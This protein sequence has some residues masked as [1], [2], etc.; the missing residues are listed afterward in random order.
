MVSREKSSGPSTMAL[1]CSLAKQWVKSN[2]ERHEDGVVAKAVMYKH[3]EDHCREQGRNT[4][5][6][7]I[8]G[9]VV[10]S[11]F[12]DVNIRRLGGRDNLKYYYCGIQAKESSPYAADNATTTR[13]KRRLR[14]RELATEKADVH[15][16]LR[17]V[18]A[19]YE[20]GP[21]HASVCKQD[22]FDRYVQD[23]VTTGADPLPL[24]CF[25]MVMS[26][27]LPQLTRRKV[28]PRANQHKFYFGLQERPVPL[29]LET[30]TVEHLANCDEMFSNGRLKYREEVDQPE[31]EDEYSSR[32]PASN[33]SASSSSASESVQMDITE[34]GEATAHEYHHQH[35]SIKDEPVD[36]SYPTLRLKEE[37]VA[38][39][40]DYLV[41]KNEPLD[42]HLPK[43]L[44]EYA[45][46]FNYSVKRSPERSPSVV[47][48]LSGSPSPPVKEHKAR[49]IYKPRFH[50]QDENSWNSDSEV[51][52]EPSEV[53]YCGESATESRSF[54]SEWLVASFEECSSSS[55]NREDVL[56][57]YEKFCSLYHETPVP[58]SSLD[59]AV[60]KE[61]DGVVTTIHPSGKTYYNGLQVKPSGQLSRF[62]SDVPETNDVYG[63]WKDTSQH[64]ME[65]SPPTGAAPRASPRLLDDGDASQE[66]YGEK[67][68]IDG[69][70]EDF[71]S[72]PEVM[73]DGKFYL[74]MW[75]TENFESVP[76]S[77]VL[78]ADAYRHYEA[79][80]KSINQT[81]FE[82]NVFGKI[83]RQVFPKVS[84][85]RLGG[86]IK[87][88]YHYCGIAVKHSSPLFQYMSGKDPAQRSRKKE[89]ATDNKSAE[90]VIDWLQ[91]NYEPGKEHAIMKSEVF[92]KYCDF[93]TSRNEN[94]V[95][96]NYFGKL[97]KHCFPQVEVRKCGG[98]S[99][100]TWYYNGLLPKGDDRAGS[101]Y[102]RSHVA[103]PAPPPHG[104]DELVRGEGGG[105][106]GGGG[107]PSPGDLKVP[108]SHG[109]YQRGA[110]PTLREDLLASMSVHSTSSPI[111]ITASE[112]ACVSST[113]YGLMGSPLMLQSML[114][115]PSFTQS[116]LLKRRSPFPEHYQ[117]SSRDR[118]SPHHAM[119][120]IRVRQTD[121]Y[122]NSPSGL[123]ETL[124]SQSPVESGRLRHPHPHHPHPQQQQQQGG[125]SMTGVG[126]LQELRRHLLAR[127]P[128]EPAD[129]PPENVFSR[130]PGDVTAQFSRSPQDSSMARSP[131]PVLHY[132][133][134][135]LDT[136]SMF[137]NSPVESLYA[138]G[139]HER[140]PEPHG[141]VGGTMGGPQVVPTRTPPSGIEYNYYKD[142]SS[143][144][145]DRRS[146]GR[147]DECDMLSEITLE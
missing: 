42:L 79:Y 108:T 51:K 104:Y 85:R 116:P 127:S 72:T 10:K 19:L 143:S 39:E 91:S 16:C 29:T 121:L 100:P 13:P 96:L 73:R 118:P 12:P 103:S 145:E 4:M 23:C 11:V 76:D 109:A 46:P 35:H 83:V 128:H 44:S 133:R 131:D 140:Y 80:I 30:V 34:F 82:M 142:S 37:R 48:S 101:P 84:I 9:R 106:G 47:T 88:Q 86:R 134:S 1:S 89:I 7:S 50:Y 136:T 132:S 146:L 135:P 54:L 58:L 41:T 49:R 70:E 94:P 144:H 113:A 32:S 139:M 92:M 33:A 137:S 107:V 129:I 17:W 60:F 21:P 69:P 14:K 81:P 61:F 22:M 67:F 57:L 55:V 5:E 78:K 119:Q 64:S 65:M 123:R 97:V 28:G 90:V 56:S 105:G 63:S 110:S 124:D 15:R 53:K 59:V 125:G 40:E 77:C 102:T 141:V 74:R 8:F 120:G 126:G 31:D 3:Y 68:T 36:Y 26:H 117:Q 71:H 27:A 52:T 75:L 87:P 38:L 2:Y 112:G 122:P 25:G 95:T 114:Q 6:T 130:S 62:V 43:D 24:Q 66:R 99:E 138:V 93:C 20:A 98:R 115:R 111:P 18:H 147:Y 45:Q